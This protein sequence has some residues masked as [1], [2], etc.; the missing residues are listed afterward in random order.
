MLFRKIPPTLDRNGGTHNY[1]PVF[2]EMVSMCLNK[3]PS[4]RPTA[5]KLLIT[6]FFKSAT[7][8]S[9]LVGAIL[10]K[11]PPLTQRQERMRHPSILTSPTMDSWDFSTSTASP[12]TSVQGNIAEQDSEYT[13][14]YVDRM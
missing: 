5:A 3:D 9:Y 2:E 13:T 4:L 14:T 11:L 6:H 10:S 8:K 7:K 12:K 1:S